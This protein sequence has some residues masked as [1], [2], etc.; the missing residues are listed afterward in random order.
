MGNPIRYIDPTGH[1]YDCG[2]WACPEDMRDEKPKHTNLQPSGNQLQFNISAGFTLGLSNLPGTS[3]MEDKT[4]ILYYSLSVV[5]DR[6]GNIQVYYLERDQGEAEKASPTRALTAGASAAYGVIY[7]S[8]FDERGTEAYSGQSVDDAVSIDILTVDRYS[9][10]D[11]I[12][13]KVSPSLLDGYDVGISAGAP[14]GGAHVATNAIPVEIK[15]PISGATIPLKVQIPVFLI[16][17]C[18]S[19]GQCGAYPSAVP[20]F[21]PFLRET[22]SYM[23][24]YFW[25]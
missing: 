22:I 14:A 1:D 13:K 5:T 17:L 20:A 19:R 16:P 23:N 8:L 7:G 11:K 9:Y 6:Y 2:V 24:Y 21:I 3:K 15:S 25:R 18:Q 4:V 12:T 10:F